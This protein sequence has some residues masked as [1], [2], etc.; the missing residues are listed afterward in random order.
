MRIYNVTGYSLIGVHLV[1]SGLAA[2]SKWGFLA[3]ALGE[4]D[5][6]FLTVRVMK[7]MGLVKATASGVQK[8]EGVLLQDIGL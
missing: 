8:P 3:G 1:T 4:Y 6:G 2:P 5:F 7:A